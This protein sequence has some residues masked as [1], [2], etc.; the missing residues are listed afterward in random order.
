ML[1]GA[2]RFTLVEAL[3]RFMPGC[4][5]QSCALRH[6]PR[7]VAI[8][9]RS[10]HSTISPATMCASK[11]AS[12][13]R[14]GIFPES[15]DGY[16]FLILPTTGA[17]GTCPSA[18]VP[19]ASAIFLLQEGGIGGTNFPA[20][21]REPEC[22]AAFTDR[23]RRRPGGPSLCNAPKRSNQVNMGAYIRIGRQGALI[24]G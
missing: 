23:R 1:A 17:I 12:T 13:T 14:I 11:L 24:S 16:G 5:T 7:Q 6:D 9:A 8:R 10:M 18:L 20:S 2:R 22:S 19:K 3:L 21:P 4:G 15:S